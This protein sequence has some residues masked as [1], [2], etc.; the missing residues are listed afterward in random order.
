MLSAAQIAE[1]LDQSFQLLTRGVTDELPRHQ[2]LRAT[3]DWSYGL[4]TPLEQVLLRRLSVFAGSFT[5]EMAEAVTSD[6]N[7]AQPQSP[8]LQRED[9]LD[10]LSNLMDK[11]LLSVQEADSQGVARFRLL[12]TVRQYA[13][14]KLEAA[15]DSVVIRDRYLDWCI[16]WAE[17]GKSHLVHAEQSIWL[18]R[19][20]SQQ[21]HFR[22]SLRWACTRAPTRDARAWEG[23]PPA[24]QRVEAG[25][26]LANALLRLW[27]TGGMA[28]GR[29]WLEELLYLDSSQRQA[30]MPQ[31]PD[32]TRAWA[33]FGSGRLAVRLGDDAHAMQRGEQSLALF[34][35]V[36]DS[37]GRL[38]ALNLLALA[39]QDT[40]DYERALT[41]YREALDL[42]RQTNDTR[43][44]Y[45]LLV[46]QGLMYYEQQDYQHTKPL[47]LEA[48]E[49]AERE[50]YSSTLDNLA[51]LAM[52]QGDLAQARH[53]LEQ[54][55]KTAVDTG[56][57]LLVAL[58]VMDLGEATRRQGDLDRA[59]A[60]LSD[61]L[62][63]HRQMSNH[64]RIGEALVYLAH[65]ARNRGQIHA[66]RRAYEQ[67]LPH[68]EKT[69]YTRFISHAQIGLGR[70][71]SLEGRDDAALALFR[72][73][74]QVAHKGNHQLCQ[75]EALEGIA[76]IWARQGKAQDAARLCAVAALRRVALGA[77]LP[78]VEFAAYRQL[79]DGLRATLGD[80]FVSI[81]AEA[82]AANLDSLLAEILGEAPA[83][84][85]GAVCPSEPEVRIYALGATRVLVNGRALSNS[86]WTYSK[87]K[88][89]FHYLLVHPRV[90]KEQIGVELWPDAS[91]AQLRNLFHRA[92]YYVRKALGH[93]E[94]I[95]FENGEYA[96][97][98]D[99]RLWSDVAAF[100]ESLARARP[101]LKLGM[102]QA[103]ERER[104]RQ[105][106]EA[107][108][109]LWQGDFLTGMDA[110]EWAM[111]YGEALRRAYATALMD[112][113]Q[114]HVADARYADALE[115]Y[116]RMLSADNLFEAAHRELMRCYARV[117]ES[118]RALRHYQS[119]RRLLRAEL[120]AEPS[121]ETTLLF[122]RL[123]RGDDI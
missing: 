22:A 56:D 9:I 1:R 75:V 105:F 57:Q 91:P 95:A 45:V 82:R 39:A 62:E 76:T 20:A 80:A 21:E 59:Q 12:E 52:M 67:S 35:A 81:Q 98:Q 6:Q 38:A 17:Q 83:P 25:M 44:T 48:N 93:A 60:L 41:L 123:R 90:S 106:L 2:T 26:R 4:L 107:A 120:A 99:S 29:D 58:A 92:L 37:A 18:K 104:A 27:L 89:L 7:N 94:W 87:S 55:W 88:E 78:P 77:P 72:E 64:V 115:V 100:E 11:S 5:V 30:A 19:F 34:R 84:P 13:R 112:L 15:G 43:M 102:P 61:A 63:R 32:A 108:V 42:S 16:A 47:W 46:N 74:L 73:G 71:E 50:G 8:A 101:L 24:S 65:A 68:L 28:E 109:Q 31:V 70:L 36:G 86:D 97:T 51:C 118:N 54:E 113:G 85:A 119:L 117:G 116:Q 40:G 53:W 66:A 122:E 111:R 79:E 103:V 3:M 114:L 49:I 121:P 33:L 10:L 23:T 14:E 69:N 110:G 96:L